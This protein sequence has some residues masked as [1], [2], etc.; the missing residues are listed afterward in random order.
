MGGA[1]P[2]VVGA[3]PPVPPKLFRPEVAGPALVTPRRARPLVIIA[4]CLEATSSPPGVAPVSYTNLTT[5]T[6][7]RVY[8]YVG[9]GACKEN[10]ILV[11]DAR[12]T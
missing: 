7:L 2:G 11:E 9:V 4:F 8:D 5:P 12:A 6:I 3:P 1:G 10:K